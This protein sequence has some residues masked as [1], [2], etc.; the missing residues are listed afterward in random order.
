MRISDWSSDVCSS[1]LMG[2]DV[3][4]VEVSALK[5]IGLDALIDKVM[6]Q[7]EIMEMKANPDRAAEGTVIAAKLDQGRGPVATI[8]INRG[9]LHLGDIFVVGASSRKVRALLHAK[10]HSVKTA[11]PLVPSQGL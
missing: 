10:G 4:D 11:G 5:K 1:D 9:T 8:L 6:L 3:Q 2:G 7:A